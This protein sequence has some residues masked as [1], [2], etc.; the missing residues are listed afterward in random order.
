MMIPPS[1]R[2]HFAERAKDLS[3][4]AGLPQS[5]PK[6]FRAKGRGSGWTTTWWPWPQMEA[7]S[8]IQQQQQQQQQQHHKYQRVA[9]SNLPWPRVGVKDEFGP[10]LLHESHEALSHSSIWTAQFLYVGADDVI[11]LASHSS[12]LAPL[13]HPSNLCFF[14]PKFVRPGPAGAAANFTH[15]PAFQWPPLPTIVLYSMRVWARPSRA[16]CLT[17]LR[18]GQAGKR[19]QPFHLQPSLSLGRSLCEQ[20]VG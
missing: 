11:R 20:A 16:R 5:R 12:C 8:K 6:S 2:L 10:S 7:D 17:G 3:E 9:L 4:S 13:I 14:R 1:P 18:R 19:A 15:L